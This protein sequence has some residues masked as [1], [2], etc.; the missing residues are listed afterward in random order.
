MKSKLST[1][2]PLLVSLLAL[3]LSLGVALSPGKSGPQGPEE[4]AGGLS[5]L[6]E[7][8]LND[9]KAYKPFNLSISDDAVIT[10]T[11]SNTIGATLWIDPTSMTL[12]TSG[13]STASSYR[14]QGAAT[15]TTRQNSVFE[16][17]GREARLLLDETIATSSG[18]QQRRASST[19][20]RLIPWYAGHA[21]EFTIRGTFVTESDTGCA[22]S[23]G[24][25]AATSSLRNLGTVNFI[26]DTFSTSTDSLSKARN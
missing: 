1:L 3:G 20:T 22:A 21:V 2:V 25:Q 19:A 26:F 14:I 15:S 11:A 13:T 6:D 8:A 12:V 24:C 17:M 4:K 16:L 7:L 23:Q 9:A 5:N 10:V 18:P